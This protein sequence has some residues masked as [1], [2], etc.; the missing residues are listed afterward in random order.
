MKSIVTDVN[1]TEFVWRELAER[2]QT[3]V[4]V[5]GNPTDR[6]TEHLQNA[7]QLRVSLGQLDR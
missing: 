4:R 2:R 3:S 7:N 1:I 5:V 6:A